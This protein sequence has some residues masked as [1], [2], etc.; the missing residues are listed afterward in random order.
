MY[1][2]NELLKL[3]NDYLLNNK[4]DLEP[5]GLY[6]PV[7]YIMGLGGKRIR[8]LVCLMTANIFNDDLSGIYPLSYAVE[9]FHNFTLLHDDIMDNAEIRR[10][11]PTVHKKYDNNTAIL[12]GD[13][14]MIKSFQYILN[15]KIETENKI[16]ILDLFTKTAI[17]VCEGQQY[18]MDFESM[19][20]LDI[21]IYL[22]MIKL[23]TAVLLAYS[24]K[25]GAL[26]GG[27]SEKDAELFYDYGINLGLAFQ[28]QDDLLDL[29]GDEKVFGKIKGGD[30]LQKKKSYLYLKALEQ[31]VDKAKLIDDYNSDFESSDSKVEYFL[32]IYDDLQIPEKAKDEIENYNQKALK[33]LDSLSVD[34]TKL[35]EIIEL[36]DFLMAREY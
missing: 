35:K 14:M 8:P 6:H 33:N 34:K 36:H 20:S 2:Y 19:R 4:F 3:F 31:T 1:S 17:E 11:K 28:I 29:Y 26:A 23:K 21:D 13:L 18:D 27:A 10:G 7:N 25:S 24:F 32:K 16:K 5:R 12:S 30:I 9:M 15:T 22:K